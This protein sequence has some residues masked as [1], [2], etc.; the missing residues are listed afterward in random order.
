MIRVIS[1]FDF[2]LDREKKEKSNVIAVET[3]VRSMEKIGEYWKEI[4]REN[5]IAKSFV[6]LRGGERRERGR[7]IKF[8]FDFARGEFLLYV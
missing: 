8:Y 7:I 6:F 2:D 4:G 3:C 5:V 1:F